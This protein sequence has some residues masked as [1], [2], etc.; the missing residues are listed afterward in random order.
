MRLGDP[1]DDRKTEPRAAPLA[2]F[3]SRARGVRAVETVED[4]G[5]RFGRDWHW[6]SSRWAQ[7]NLTTGYLQIVGTRD[8]VHAAF[9][10]APE[11]RFALA[12]MPRQ[13]GTGWLQMN[14]GVGGEHWAWLLSYNQQA[15]DE[16]M[17][18]GMKLN[19]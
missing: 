4:V 7:L 15:G 16:A 12:G 1:P 10:G 3:A 17:T 9:T 14:L 13:R 5:L 11:A 18:L 6:G 19:F 8:D 2:R